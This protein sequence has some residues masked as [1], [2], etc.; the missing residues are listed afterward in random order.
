MGPSGNFS[1]F[2]GYLDIE[3]LRELNK[4]TSLSGTNSPTL[5]TIKGAPKSSKHLP[6]GVLIR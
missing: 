2:G 1:D 4:I 3:E 6:V 5:I